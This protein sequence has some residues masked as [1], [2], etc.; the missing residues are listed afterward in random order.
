MKVAVVDYGMG[1]LGSVRRALEELRRRGRSSPT[2]PTRWRGAD[3]IVLPGVGAFGDGDGAACARRAGSR[4]CGEQVADRASRC[5]V[6]ASA[7]SCWPTS[8][9][10][11]RRASR[12]SG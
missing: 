6:S 7:C 5:W 4:R 2:I 10:G 12:A 1:N 3:R 8:S 11:R 9:D